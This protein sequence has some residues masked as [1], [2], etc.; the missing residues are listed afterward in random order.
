MDDDCPQI[1]FMATRGYDSVVWS[2][3]YS[4]DIEY[5][6]DYQI[7]QVVYYNAH[8]VGISYYFDALIAEVHSPQR[9]I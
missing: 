8:V 9:K 4:R 6:P 5:L 2:R 7:N 3:L 1:P